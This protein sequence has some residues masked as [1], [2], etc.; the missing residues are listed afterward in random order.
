MIDSNIYFYFLFYFFDF[1]LFVKLFYK[2]GII[3]KLFCIKV[4]EMV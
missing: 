2:I 3:Y 1:I 4:K